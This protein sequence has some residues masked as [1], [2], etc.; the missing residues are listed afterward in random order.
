MR[1]VVLVTDRVC[2]LCG[3]SHT[4]GTV[5]VATQYSRLSPIRYRETVLTAEL[6]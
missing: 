4:S 5:T 6:Q 3:K 1:E 2:G